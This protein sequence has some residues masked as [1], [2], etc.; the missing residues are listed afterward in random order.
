MHRWEEGMNGHIARNL[1][2]LDSRVTKKKKSK[3]KPNPNLN[4]KTKTKQRPQQTKTKTK[5]RQKQTNPSKN[6]EKEWK[7]LAKIELCCLDI[8]K[9]V[10]I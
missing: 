6:Q 8:A 7:I 1:V 2:F 9:V 4:P 5:Q 10:D 3:T